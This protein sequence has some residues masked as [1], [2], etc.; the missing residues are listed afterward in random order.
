M[1]PYN[2][3]HF[4]LQQVQLV[5]VTEGMILRDDKYIPFA[6]YKERGHKVLGVSKP[7]AHTDHLCVVSF[8]GMVRR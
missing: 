8:P 3:C 2:Q 5:K 4:S 1:T 7:I 6:I